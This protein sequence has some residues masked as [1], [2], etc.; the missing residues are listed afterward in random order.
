[1]LYAFLMRSIL[2]SYMVHRANNAD[3][4]SSN[5]VICPFS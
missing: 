1:M 2:Q 3:L 4:C 5:A